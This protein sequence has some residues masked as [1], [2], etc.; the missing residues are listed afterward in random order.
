MA[1][2]RCAGEPQ[3]VPRARRD[4]LICDLPTVGW[5][6]FVTPRRSR[7]PTTSGWRCTTARRSATP[8]T[9]AVGEAGRPLYTEADL[10]GDR[11]DRPPGRLSVHARRV[12]VDVPRPPVD[13]A[14]VRG[15]RH[16]GGDQRALPLPARAR[17]DGAVDRVRHAVAD[18]PRLRPPAVAGRGRARGRGGRHAR[19]HGRR[20]SAASSSARS[21]CR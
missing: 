15:L 14:P 4:A 12:P 8:S 17:P 7:P 3:L 5:P 2:E 19:R 11:R 20:C 13:D 1:R 10:P 6:H 18:G 16:G 9:D 21:R